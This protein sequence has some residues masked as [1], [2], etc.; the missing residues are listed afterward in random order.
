MWSWDDF[1][2]A[3][4]QCR[5][6]QAGAN[7]APVVVSHETIQILGGCGAHVRLGAWQQAII[8][9]RGSTS[10]AVLRGYQSDDLAGVLPVR[11][12]DVKS[13]ELRLS[14]P[15]SWCL[16]FGEFAGCALKNLRKINCALERP[17]TE[18]IAVAKITR[19]LS[20]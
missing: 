10:C 20:D 15:V 7:P 19:L 8:M 1:K 18:T 16:A 5:V 6:G 12:F 13:V 9:N 2:V 14:R 4:W 17:V 11:A 3:T